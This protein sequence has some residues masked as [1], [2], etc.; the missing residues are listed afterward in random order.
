MEKV[1]ISSYIKKDKL[2]IFLIVILSIISAIFTVF[3]PRILGL[4]TTKLADGIANNINI[5]VDYILKMIILAIVFYILCFVFRIIITEVMNNYSQNLVYVI[6]N[7][8]QKKINRL[9]VSYFESRNDG[10]ILSKI[11]NDVDIISIGLNSIVANAGSSIVTIVGIIIMMFYINFIMA[12]IVISILFLT[13]TSLSILMVKMKNSF[14]KQQIFLANANSNVEEYYSAIETIKSLVVENKVID[15]YDDINKEYTKASK[16]SIFYSLLV[17]PITFFIT[18]F[19]YVAVIFIGAYLAF[20]GTIAVGDIFTFASY[21]NSIISPVQQLGTVLASFK[22]MQV[23]SKRIFDFLNEEE[24]IINENAVT[25]EGLNDSISFNN[26]S[27]GYNENNIIIRDFNENIKKGTKVAIVG[28]TG[29]GKTTIVKLLLRFYDINSGN[30]LF[31]N[32]NIKNIDRKSLRKHYSMVLQESW[33]FNGS[34]YENIKFGKENATLEEVKNAAKLATADKYIEL[35]PNKYDFIIDEDANNLSEGQKQ[36]IMI[37]RAF[38][39]DSEVLI[40]D[41]AT[42]SVDT[43]T[44]AYVKKDMDDLMKNKTTFVIAHRL[45]TIQNADVILVLKDGNIIEKGTHEELIKKKGYYS[46]LYNMQFA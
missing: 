9:P 13:L 28:G 36:L 46:E 38:L 20:I 22:Q 5:D 37:A 29:A 31:D 3:A 11:V 39:S 35:L 14:D 17:N 25:I 40:L 18:F 44:E 33:L 42:S 16:M 8:V 26:V 27:F 43:R 19:G 1:T 34:V 45:S 10:E 23:A 12:I 6:R 30:I 41:E 15:K 4:A 2:L 24:E 21:T 32:I 7:D